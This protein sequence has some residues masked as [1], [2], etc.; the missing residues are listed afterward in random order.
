MNSA[1]RH[2]EA[3]SR[4]WDVYEYFHPGIMRQVDGSMNSATRHLE[5]GSWEET[6]MNSAI[7]HLEAGSWDRDAGSWAGK[8][9]E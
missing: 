8:V 4:A 9:Y 6:S 7:M 3:S 5:A 1:L 2:L